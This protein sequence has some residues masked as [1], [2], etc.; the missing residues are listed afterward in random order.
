MLQGSKLFQLSRLFLTRTLLY[1]ITSK[2]HLREMNYFWSE[3][4][5]ASSLAEDLR[6]T[7]QDYLS[8]GQSLI[9]KFSA[10]LERRFIRCK[11]RKKMP[12]FQFSFK[13]LVNLVLDFKLSLIKMWSKFLSTHEPGW[14]A[15]GRREQGETAVQRLCCS[16]LTLQLPQLVSELCAQHQNPRHVSVWQRK[17]SFSE[18]IELWILSPMIYGAVQRRRWGAVRKARTVWSLMK[19]HK[20]KWED[21]SLHARGWETWA[22]SASASVC[23]YSPAKMTCETYAKKKQNSFC[24]CIPFNLLTVRTSQRTNKRTPS[25]LFSEKKCQT[26][27]WWDVCRVCLS[28]GDSRI[29]CGM[30]TVWSVGAVLC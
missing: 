30:N 3:D 5:E 15:G 13:N 17:L 21:G 6:A 20:N 14:P 22:S 28:S 19:C 18:L 16:V 4:E 23:S 27:A 12:E 11:H 9:L 10:S 2:K 24:S 8:Q 29:V 25:C 7:W 1:M 26:P